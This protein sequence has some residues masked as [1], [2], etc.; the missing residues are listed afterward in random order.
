MTVVIPAVAVEEFSA[1]QKREVVM[2]YQET[3]HGKKGLYLESIGVSRDRV[4]TWRKQLIAGNIDTGLTPRENVRMSASDVNEIRRLQ[5]L[6]ESLSSR[7]AELEGE[8]EEKDKQ[9]VAKDEQLSVKDEQN[10]AHARAVDSLGK[11][12]AI[13]QKY[14]DR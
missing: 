1:D 6:T 11:A 13:M 8:L 10:A 4:K 9:L 12:I 3:P 7:I 14:T 5:E 2:R